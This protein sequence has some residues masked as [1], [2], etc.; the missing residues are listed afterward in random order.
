[1]SAVN[2]N[3]EPNYE[4]LAPLRSVPSVPNVWHLPPCEAITR[5]VQQFVFSKKELTGGIGY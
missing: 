5:D 2:Q 3:N 1:M 4:T